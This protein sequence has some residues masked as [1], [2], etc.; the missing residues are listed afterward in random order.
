MINKISVIVRNYVH[1][2]VII[3]NISQ[4]LMFNVLNIKYNTILKMFWLCNRNSKLIKLIRTIYDKIHIKILKQS[5][6]YLS[7]HR[8]W[9][10]EILLLKKEQ[11]KW[12]LL[13]LMSE[14]QLKK[15]WNYLDENFKR[16]FIKSLKSL[17]NYLILFVSKKNEKKQLCVDYQQLNTITKQ[18]SYSLLLI[19]ELQD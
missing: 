11:F 2:K 12:M 18:N 8:T 5:K 1:I 14:N 9:Y 17:T 19:E 13:Y 15:V 7:E 6:M 10:H 16:K 4:K 3:E